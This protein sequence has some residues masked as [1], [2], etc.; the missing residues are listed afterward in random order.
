MTASGEQQISER[1]ADTGSPPQREHQLVCVVRTALILLLAF[2]LASFPARN[3][4][5]W[6]HLATGRALV[7]GNYH[8]GAHPFA[9]TTEDDHWVNHAWLYH[10][11]AFSVYQSL[12]EAGLV[13]SKALLVVLVCGLLMHVAWRRT[14]RWLAALCVIL[15]V[16]ALG[17]YLVLRPVIVSYLFLAATVWWLE[18]RGFGVKGKVGSWLPLLL[19]FILWANLDEWFLLGPLTV[20]LYWIGEVLEAQSPHPRP[21]SPLGAKGEVAR[22]PLL[23]AANGVGNVQSQP[24]RLRAAGLL[25]A[26]GLVICLMNPH[27]IRTFTLPAV[28]APADAG[29]LSD[30]PPGWDASPFGTTYF[31]LGLSISPAGLAYYLLVLLGVLSFTA[32]FLTSGRS[33]SGHEECAGWSRFLAWLALFALSA[34]TSAMIPF[35]A[36]AAA[37][38]T[39][40]NLQQAVDRRRRTECQ[41]ASP[42]YARWRQALSLLVLTGLCV[43]A[44]PGWLQP[45]PF[46]PRRW[47]IETDPAL[48]KTAFEITR[49]REVGQIGDEARGFNL[50][51]AMASYLAWFAPQEKGF[52]CPARG[53]GYFPAH[54]QRKFLAVRRALTDERPRAQGDEVHADWRAILQKAGISHINVHDSNER[55][56]TA[57][58]RNLLASPAEWQ[59]AHVE[60]RAAIFA[61]RAAA[62]RH[63]AGA[64]AV[65][66]LELDDLAFRPAAELTS[67]T[68][69]P[70]PRSW[71]DAFWKPRRQADVHRDLAL[72]YRAHFEALGPVYRE[73]HR[74]LWET[75]LAAGLIGTFA[76]GF[77]IGSPAIGHYLPL[78]QISRQPLPA[79][80]EQQPDPF[81]RLAYRLMAD[82]V[83]RRDDGPVGSLHMMVRATRRALQADPDDALTHWLL[84]DGYLR[85]MRNSSERAAASSFPLLNTLRK[86][87]AI[88]ALKNAVLLK[89]D[90]IA[91]HER[92]AALYQDMTFLD[93]ALPHLQDQLKYSR[94][95]GPRAGETEGQLAE[96]L[97]TLEENVERLGKRVRE[98]LNLHEIQAFEQDVFSRARIAQNIGLP[99][100]ALEILLNSQY[101]AFGRDGALMELQLFLYTGRA[102]EVRAWMEPTQEAVLGSFHYRWLQAQWAAAVG[103]YAQADHDLQ[104]LTVTGVDVPHFN[105]KNAPQRPVIALFIG[106]SVLDAAQPL[107][108]W[109]ESRDSMLKR[110]E[111]LATH[112]RQQA[113][114]AA[115]RGLLAME[116]G[117]VAA[118]QRLFRGSLALW[119][120]PSS[121]ALLCRHYLHLIRERGHP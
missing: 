45:F 73:R 31:Q 101:E 65:P 10:L 1:S 58:L 3:S 25:C 77:A 111:S 20:F 104:R 27:H 42:R 103:D 8:F 72:V 47:A 98:L 95:A 60:G 75:G 15:A 90:L 86:V 19:M 68:R 52:P 61:W 115:L 120:S 97:R 78:L 55:K 116:A 28:L 89:P 102:S 112:L 11:L 105:L 56:L 40:L 76:D 34:Y 91:A 109:Q 32:S 39:A 64:F 41:A 57:A 22:T 26:A 43:A 63:E 23:P 118:A 51:P 82:F 106:Q 30:D 46:E 59:L 16:L 53:L 14:N 84:G 36:V 99:G 6:M 54:V 24:G 74:L 114:V 67:A 80:L 44:W 70:E 107:S 96:R 71:W 93:L 81:R 12:G 79:Q 18:R 7:Q 85:L 62:S 48:E 108:H 66:A 50:S 113:E 5:V 9:L 21:L 13:V 38:I 110:V 33:A 100:K 87:Q 92:L 17:P 83:T 69:H 121:P 94:A 88:I 2:L 37:P 29:E 119:S 49:W 35:F 4:D 117:D